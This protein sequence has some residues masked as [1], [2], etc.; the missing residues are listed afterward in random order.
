MQ[1][2]SLRSWKQGIKEVDHSNRLRVAHPYKFYL[3]D[4]LTDIAAIVQQTSAA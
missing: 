2:D 4:I 1:M 3:H